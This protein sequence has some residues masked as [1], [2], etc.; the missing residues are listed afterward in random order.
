MMSAFL[1]LSWSSSENYKV[2]HVAHEVI[3]I[4]LVVVKSPKG[5][6][7]VTLRIEFGMQNTQL[8]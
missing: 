2:N 4:N 3:N 7:F 8:H 5:C 1:L 6:C